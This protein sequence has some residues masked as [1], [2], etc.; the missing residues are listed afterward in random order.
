MTIGCAKGAPRF[1]APP[2]MACGA[3]IAR[4]AGYCGAWGSAQ[5]S[6]GSGEPSWA[7]AGVATA[8]AV[9]AAMESQ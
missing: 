6:G 1:C 5:T 3:G 7:R 9:A 2:G 8:Q 4:G